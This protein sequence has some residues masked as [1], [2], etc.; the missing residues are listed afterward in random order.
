MTTDISTILS[1]DTIDLSLFEI[2]GARSGINNARSTGPVYTG[3]TYVPADSSVSGAGTFSSDTTVSGFSFAPPYGSLDTDSLKVGD[4]L[5]SN[6]VTFRITNIDTINSFQIDPAAA[7]SGGYPLSL[8]LDQREYVVEPDVIEN[9]TTGQANFF[10]GSVAVTGSGF[11]ALTG[12][13]FIKHDAYQTFF[14]IDQVIND[15]SLNLV[16]TYSGDTTSGPY[17][18]KR[19]I[20]GRTKIQYAKNNFTYD[21]QSAK[22][23]YDSITGNDLTTS[24][25]FAPLADGIDM[26][27]TR[28]LNVNEPDLMDVAV[29]N[30]QTFASETQYETFQFA[31]PVVPFPEVS[32]ELFINDVKK[33]MFQ[34]YVLTYSQSPLYEPPP[35]PNQRFVANVMFLDGVDNVA[36]SSTLSE[37][38]QIVL[39]DSEGEAIPGIFAGSETITINGTDQT[40]LQDYMLEPNTG[41][42]E[43]TDTVINEPIVKYVSDDFSDYIDYGFS[44]FLNGKKQKI[45][46]PAEADDDILFQVA[47]GRLKPRDKDHP[48]PGEVYQVNY[49]VETTSVSNET[50]QGIAGET[51]LELNRYP[52]KQD[53][54]FLAKNKAFLEEGVDFFVSYLTGRILLEV[55]STDT[56][57]FKVNYTP[58]SK[59]VNELFY[60]DGSWYCTVNDS[61][62]TIQDAANFKFTLA[63]RNLDVENITIL[64]IYN[65]T[66]DKDYS[67][68]GFSTDGTVIIL[69]KNSINVSVGLD[70]DDVVVIDYKFI[71]LQDPGNYVEYF[72]VVVN[73]LIVEEGSK[74]VYIEGSDLTS[75]IDSSSVM[76]LARPDAASETFHT[77]ESASY[78]NYG[79]RINI[80][81]SVP[82]DITN[83][84]I[85]ISDSAPSYLTVPLQAD[86][87]VTG[88]TSMTF[89]GTNIRDIFRPYTLLDVDDDIYQVSGSAYDTET[90]KTVV[91]L[92]SEIL[93]DQTDSTV[94]SNVLYTDNPI[95]PEGSTDIT[96]SKSAITLFNQSAFVM[97]NDSDRILSV[98]STAIGMTI[99]GTAFSY[100]NSSTLGDLSSAIDSSNIDALALTTYAS[101][102]QSDKIIPVTDVSVY[103]DSSTVLYATDALRYKDIDATVYTDS[104]N[105]TVTEAGTIL[106]EN[107]L[108]RGDRYNLD[109][110]GRQFLGDDQLEYSLRYFTS[111]P[112]KS[113]VSASFQYIN[114]D[115]FYIQVMNQ[116]DFFERVTIPRMEEEA[117]QLSG[118]VGQGGTL[119]S[120]DGA[121]NDDGGITG[122]EYTRRDTEIECG[123]FEN[124]YDFFQNR[125]EDYGLEMEAAFGLGL[126]NNDGTFSKAEQDGAAKVISRIFPSADYTNFDPMQVN[127]LTGY[128][129]DSDARFTKNSLTVTGTGTHWTDQLLADGYIGSVD[130]TRRYEILSV[131]GPTSLTLK[132]DFEEKT[133]TGEYTAT[134]NSYPVYDDDGF[135]GGK[136]IGSKNKD[137]GILSG[138]A[139]N[140]IIDGVGK[141]YTFEF[142]TGPF[143]GDFFSDPDGPAIARIL[144]SNVSGLSCSFERVLDPTTT[145]GYKSTLVMRTTYPSNLLEM[146]DNTTVDKL[147]FSSDQTAVGNLD[148]ADHRPEIDL[149]GYERGFIAAEKTE[150]DTLIGYSNKL[151]RASPAGLIATNDAEIEMENERDTILEEIQKLQAEISATGD[152]IAEGG[153]PSGDTSAA[154]LAATLQLVDTQLAL[155]AIN[156]ITPGWQGKGTNWKWSLD[157]S[158]HNVFIR[159]KDATDVGVA[160]GGTPIEGQTFFILQASPGYDRRILNATLFASPYMPVITGEGDNSSIAGT[161]SP[162]EISPNDYSVNNEITFI[163]NTPTVITLTDTTTVSNLRYVTDETAVNLLWEI[164]GDTYQEVY[165]YTDYNSVGAIKAVLNASAVVSATGSAVYNSD[166]SEAF[167]LDTQLINPNAT[168]KPG[169]RDAKVNYQTISERLLEDRTDFIVARDL[170]LS[171][172]IT[173]LTSRVPQILSSIASEELLLDS[174]GN[175][176]DLYT[177]ANNRYNRRQ[178]CYARLKQIEAQIASN[179]S[180]LNINKNFI[181]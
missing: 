45:S 85:S 79:T 25:S 20:I 141:D 118:S 71:Q 58:L 28:A 111:L 124:I 43:V 23:K 173:Y 22:W 84:K 169:L 159:G 139:F 107:G 112:A 127:P 119:P 163:I 24:T 149:D 29:T 161:W 143:I 170:T 67:L 81:T 53:S 57:I 39:I 164:T 88:S 150:L 155:A 40:T 86:P 83:P 47:S 38:G 80:E 129:F 148:P 100:A 92:S 97:N 128:F 178:G 4:N 10:S 121:T 77:I 176:G 2:R 46:F 145:Y 75:F 154:H 98:T 26:A 134:N 181:T 108:Q 50:K 37:S 140:C 123:I 117:Q 151:D 19:W 168:I 153:I 95:Y 61:R 172:R 12:G 152:I 42:L 132:E 14:R 44:V 162:W 51:V 64:R 125:L 31:L 18:G 137:Y 122:I 138:D 175:P 106:L 5:T 63:N 136:I 99:D 56:D 32:M 167:T 76:G 102:W 104:S 70:A 101:G 27:F 33:T 147:G 48:G 1:Y 16:S 6:A 166:L 78:D 66:R 113:K 130:S 60:E 30:N 160:S 34:D 179:E 94:L 55:A 90:N 68:T 114:L 131:D 72:P 158:D 65:E 96:P 3:G 180:A 41:T 142:P 62:L 8:D 115:Q 59:Q 157:F 171:N 174:D 120:D 74:A 82:E 69:Q 35:P 52:V 87:L 54:I 144:T 135:M 165:R 36:P 13:D 146:G 11:N 133:V 103:R 7:F 91:A 9:T 89:P 21:G 17:T 49:M 116:R 109:Y 93:Y 126:F 110:L 177:W 15:N 73:Y 105:F 156:N